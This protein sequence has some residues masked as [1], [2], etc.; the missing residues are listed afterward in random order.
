MNRLVFASCL[1]SLLSSVAAL[2]AQELTGA[3]GEP[4][5]IIDP[6]TPPPS[7]QFDFGLRG[8]TS[9][10]A[11]KSY[12]RSNGFG[13]V[14]YSDTYAY[15]RASTPLFE[16][17][18]R[19]GSTIA[20]TFPDVY[21]APGTVFL[22]EGNAFYEDRWLNFRIGRG[23]IRSLVVPMP[24]LRDDDLIRYS[25]IQNPFSDGRSSAYHQFAN[26]VDASFWPTPRLFADAHLENMPSSAQAA[27]LGEF[28][29][30]SYG[31]TLGY[32]ELPALLPMA[33]VRKLGVGAN[34]YKVDA[35]GRRFN[36]DLLG[37][38][39]LNVVADPIHDVDWRLQGIYGNG[40]PNLSTLVTLNDT[41]R[42]RQVSS[43]SS[44]GYTYRR[45]LLPTFR[46]NVIGGYKRYL[47]AK[48]TQWSMAANAFYSLGLTTEIGVQYQLRSR[49]QVPEAFGD[50]YQH[51]VKLALVVALDTTSGPSFDSRDST[52]TTESGYLP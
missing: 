21:D 48:L 31:L 7:I 52:L 36:W 14:D 12:D 29:I 13:I 49:S 44:L 10:N 19:A 30:N 11:I 45:E 51:S 47:D 15:A 38:M 26:T 23:R 39:W 5:P 4:N 43:V 17:G 9:L 2:S 22:A 25:D 24:T 42:T 46:V 32:R 16:G 33:I 28:V 40:S 41:F 8:V 27:G 3:A 20:L 18:G 50:N 35:P 1:C 6:A 34:V 37:G